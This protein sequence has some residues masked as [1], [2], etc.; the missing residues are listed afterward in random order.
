MEQNKNAQAE[1]P[2]REAGMMCCTG[3]QGVGKTYQN[4]HAIADYVRDKPEIRVKGRKV[5]IFDTNGEYTTDQF[6][7]NG[8]ANFPIKTIAMKDVEAWS[9][10]PLVECRRIDAKHLGIKEKQR[11][12]QYILKVYLNGMV[13]IEDINTYIISV[14]FMEEIVGG[15]V[16]LRHRAVDVLISYQGL[17]PV[18]PRIFAN[19]RWMRL[20][21]QADSVMDIKGKV[22]NLTLFRIAQLLVNERY[23][24]GDERFFVYIHTFKNKIAGAF[25][26]DEFMEA[27]KKYLNSNKKYIKE[28]QDMNDD[29][30][31]EEAV[32]GQSNIYYRQFYG[33]VDKDKEQQKT[34]KK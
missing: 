5:L 1:A 11:A 6:A 34:I 30:S 26:K 23:F 10:S 16:N 3:I 21:Y 4:M 12:M 28:Y 22:P 8:I 32:T 31:K 7:R 29:C 24:G 18:E 15:I 9:R 14:T 17:R 19:S 27:C 33:N 13:V 25:R 20:H 2:L